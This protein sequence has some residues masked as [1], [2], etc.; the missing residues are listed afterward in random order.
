M[1]FCTLLGVYFAINR[2]SEKRRNVIN[3]EHFVIMIG[4]LNEI[5]IISLKYYL[6]MQFFLAFF[7][8]WFG[9]RVVTA[10]FLSL[11]FQH[12]DHYKSVDLVTIAPYD[13]CS[14]DS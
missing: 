11:I 7:F 9:L 5:Q 6:C 1:G 10:S 13:H 8:F 3:N 12:F 4:H 14:G 2:K